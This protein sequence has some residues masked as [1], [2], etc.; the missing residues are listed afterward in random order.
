L[1]APTRSSSGASRRGNARAAI[2]VLLGLLAVATMPVAVIATRYS[3][4]YDLL[5]AGFAIPAAMAFGAGAI[6]TGRSAQRYDV[7][8]LE[9]AGGRR[10]AR[11]GRAL[12]I[13]GFCLATS[14]LIALAVYGFL[15]YLEDR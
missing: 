15:T 13:L 10:T 9:R 11:V 8:L 7:R 12:G 3:G 14:A 5:H 6:A 2:S 1:V 4:S